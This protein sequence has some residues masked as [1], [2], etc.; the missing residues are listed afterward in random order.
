MSKINVGIVGYGNLG[1]GVEAALKLNDDFNLVSIFTRREPSAFN[2]GLIKHIDDISTY[3]GSIDVMLLCGGSATDLPK[4]GPELA[5]H[6]NTIDSFDTH[7]II[8]DYMKEIDTVSKQAS[9]LSL[10]STGWDPGLFSLSRLLSN[11]VL[12]KGNDFTFWGKGVSQGHS[13]AI[14]RIDGV[15]NAI[16]YTVPIE[17][18]LARVRAGKGEGLTTRDKHERHCYVVAKDG[19]DKDK[20]K[21]AIV[22]MPH[23]FDEYNTFVNF[24]TE[25]ELS[26][27]HSSMPHGGF[28][29]RTGEVSKGVRQKIEFNLELDSN[30]EFTAGVLV[31]Y[32]RAIAKLAKEGKTGALTVFDIPFAYLSGMGR[33][34]LIKSLL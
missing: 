24:L 13:D 14:R 5:K 32:A 25:E 8:L 2:H 18:A 29:I 30:P 15:E 23:Y 10:I 21:E 27:K 19:A 22:N 33:D 16:Q 6:F 34:E 31:A 7:A 4:Q 17:E 11:C 1:K 28:V 26:K 9:T 20:I 3:K 12:P